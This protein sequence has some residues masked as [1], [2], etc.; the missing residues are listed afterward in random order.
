MLLELM[1]IFSR[2]AGYKVNILKSVTFLYTDNKQTER[3]IRKIV[4]FM[5]AQKK[6]KCFGIN[7]T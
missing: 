6:M 4:P 2:I 5:I 7:L 1:H 3:E